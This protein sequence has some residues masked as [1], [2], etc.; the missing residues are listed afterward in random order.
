MN[1]LEEEIT[2]YVF[3][4]ITYDRLQKKCLFPASPQGVIHQHKR[5]EIYL[6]LGDPVQYVT[7]EHI[8]ELPFGGVVITPP[9]VKHY[10]YTNTGNTYHRMRLHLEPRVYDIAAEYQ[11]SLRMLLDNP[12][13]MAILPEDPMKHA[14]ALESIA[15]TADQA[16]Y[17][18]LVLPVLEL[19]LHIDRQM[20]MDGLQEKEIKCMPHLLWEILLYIHQ[21]NNFLR[22][23]SNREIAQQFYITESY[24]SRMFQQYMPVTAHRYLL[25]LKINYARS[26]LLNGLSVT[27]A[28]YA[29]GFSDCS[30]FIAIYRQYTGETPG[31]TGRQRSAPIL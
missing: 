25:G 6:N 19:V 5:Y 8:M 3:P 17:L 31:N 15:E 12:C 1:I 14:K 11:P 28:C 21:D 20:E 27:E 9:G 10:A 26:L 23:S 18:S 29:V 2:S 13:R 22:L 7:E 4:D 24:L 16:S 30:H